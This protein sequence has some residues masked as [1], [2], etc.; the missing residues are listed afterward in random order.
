MPPSWEKNIENT[1]K[2]S[3]TMYWR[4]INLEL[5]PENPLCVQDECDSTIWLGKWLQENCLSLQWIG[6]KQA[7]TPREEKFFYPKLNGGWGFG[8]GKFQFGTDPKGYL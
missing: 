1:P 8:N 3:I 7:P 2:E 6:W 4:T 5:A